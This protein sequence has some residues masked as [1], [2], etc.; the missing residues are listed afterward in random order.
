MRMVLLHQHRSN[1]VS[2]GKDTPQQSWLLLWWYPS[3]LPILLLSLSLSQHSIGGRNA[4]CYL[5]TSHYTLCHAFAWGIRACTH[6]GNYWGGFAI[7]EQKVDQI[8]GTNWD[9]KLNYEDHQTIGTGTETGI[10]L[11]IDQI[12]WHRQLERVRVFAW[13]A[14]SKL[15]INSYEKCVL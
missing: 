9:S 12:E 1:L 3:A 4:A 11:P 6:Y 5:A 2:L 13:P 14:F 8:P 7:Y 10:G 15:A